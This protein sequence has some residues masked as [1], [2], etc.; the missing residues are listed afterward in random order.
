MT[1]L[2]AAISIFSAAL[3][4]VL[5]DWLL[6]QFLPKNPTLKNVLVVFSA[7]IALVMI[8]TLLSTPANEQP[9]IVRTTPQIVSAAISPT[10]TY[11]RV[12]TFSATA[13][14]ATDTPTPPI[15]TPSRTATLQITS[16][17]Q[18]IDSGNKGVSIT[19]RESTSAAGNGNVR[20]Q[21][22]AGGKPLKW[23]FYYSQAVKDIAD[24]WTMIGDQTYVDPDLN[25]MIQL[26][27]PPNTYALNAYQSFAPIRGSWGIQ[28]ADGEELIVFPVVTGKETVVVL[29]LG[30]LEIGILDENGNAQPGAYVDVRLQTTDIAGKKIKSNR[31]GH[32]TFVSQA[33][34]RGIATT[35]VGAGTYMVTIFGYANDESVYYDISVKPGEV[36]REILTWYK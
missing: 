28:G 6:K 35:Y 30:I 36:H 22:L 13:K 27:L 19:L 16:V 5:L 9:S 17:P 3:L 32:D 2:S 21:I 4:G 12:S 23:T 7:I 20:I 15:S 8:S 11:T 34:G 10:A 14:K 33:D 25:G 26:S 31:G 29:S 24:H 1:F 18:V